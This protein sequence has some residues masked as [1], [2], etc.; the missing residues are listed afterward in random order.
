MEIIATKNQATHAKIKGL[1]NQLFVCGLA[2]AAGKLALTS[3]G[4]T[5]T[6]KS[7]SFC[8][9]MKAAR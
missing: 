8:S 1:D 2:L 7:G 9:V 6:G 3:V 4:L 5:G